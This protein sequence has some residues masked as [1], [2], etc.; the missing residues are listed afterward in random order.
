MNLISLTSTP[1][2]YAEPN[3]TLEITFILYPTPHPA[4]LELSSLLWYSEYWPPNDVY[5][6]IPETCEYVMLWQV[7]IKITDEIK[8]A[9][10][11]TLKR[12]S[13]FF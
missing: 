10:H 4:P 1:I 9:S 8:V 3:I 2:S 6:L 11:L 5:I 12:L 13:C 7:E